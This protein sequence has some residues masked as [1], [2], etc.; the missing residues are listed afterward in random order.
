M[1]KNQIV[2]FLSESNAIEKAWDYIFKQNELTNN[3]ILKTHSILMRG[4]LK[5]NELGTWRKEPVFI[6]GRE[7]KLWYAV[8][9]LI[10]NWI[11]EANNIVRGNGEKEDLIVSHH[12]LFENIHPFV[13]GNGRMGR[14]LLN[15]QR[16]KVGLP[17]LV[18]WE[19]EK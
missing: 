4:K 15:W 13:D 6:G 14:I 11:R 7:A 9:E 2:D 8:P 17:I 16:V 12:I 19:E 10:H 1:M 3:N 18:I 5:H